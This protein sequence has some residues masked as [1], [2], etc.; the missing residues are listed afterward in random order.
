MSIQ[1][2]VATSATDA[3]HVST[4]ESHQEHTRQ[5]K[6]HPE[7][8]LGFCVASGVLDAS[9]YF[10]MG[11]RPEPFTLP[12]VSIRWT[13][14]KRHGE[15]IDTNPVYAPPKPLQDGWAQGPLRPS[16]GWE[17]QI[18]VADKDTVVFDLSLADKDSGVTLTDHDSL[19]V[20]SD[21]CM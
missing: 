5:S 19:K 13:A 17:V 16:F 21:P 2:S 8:K 7:Y 14:G 11:P 3:T 20:T 1:L 12:T 10:W 4:W 6:E 18:P 9:V 15:L